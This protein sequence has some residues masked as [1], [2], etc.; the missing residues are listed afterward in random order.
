VF[1]VTVE[2]A[3]AVS[4]TK[5]D[6]FGI[7]DALRATVS[8]ATVGPLRTRPTS[9]AN[10]LS[11]VEVI[12]DVAEVP[13]AT[14]RVRGSATKRKPGGDTITVTDVEWNCPAAPVPVTVTLYLP[15]APLQVKVT[16]AGRDTLVE[17]GTQV[18]PEGVTLFATVTMPENIPRALIATEIVPDAVDWKDWNDGLT[19]NEKSLRFEK[20]EVDVTTPLTKP[21]APAARVTQLGGLLLPRHVWL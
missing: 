9:P 10:P 20:W 12:V 6:A 5:P 14:D 16:V 19:L 7:V 17:A 15:L 21:L 2:L 18:R 3:V 11:G 13:L 1:G 8:P 4:V